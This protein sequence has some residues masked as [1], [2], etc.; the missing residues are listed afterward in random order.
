VQVE[1][2]DRDRELLQIVWRSDGPQPRDAQRDATRAAACAGGSARVGRHCS[3]LDAIKRVDDPA[4]GEW[5]RWLRAPTTPLNHAIVDRSP[6]F[7]INTQNL[8]RY[9]AS[10]L[11]NAAGQ[12]V[13]SGFNQGIYAHHLYVAE[14]AHELFE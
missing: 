8:M 14:I 4:E 7:F 11:I 9:F 13:A 10:P 2:R 3:D 6:Y 1:A 12:P 5:F